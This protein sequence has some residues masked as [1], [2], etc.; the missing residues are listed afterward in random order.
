[1]FTLRTLSRTQAAGIHLAISVVLAAIVLAALLFVWYPQPYFRLAG[2]AGL[3]L[4]LIGV[5]VVMGPLMTLV[6]FNPAKQSL[7]VDLAVIALLQVGALLYGISVIAQARPAY[8]VFAGDHFT[9][10]G[11]NAID[12]ESL[13]AARPPYDGLPLGGPKIVGAKLPA[14]PAERNK[15]MM[16]AAGGLDLPVLPRYYVPFAEVVSELKA[17]SQSLDALEKRKPELKA[18]LDTAIARSG[19]ARSALAWVPVLG[20]LEVGIALVDL[21]RGD[22]VSVVPV[23]PF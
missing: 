19:V 5:D 12:P 20:R 7:R 23:D 13:A 4:I 8:V 2:G 1:M 11:A 14:D 9:V 18:A 16:L 17:K 3:M 22:V 15:V 10:V 6:V 21:S